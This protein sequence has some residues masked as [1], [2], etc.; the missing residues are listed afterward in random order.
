MHA[1]HRTQTVQFT[2]EGLV[3]T[4]I[5]SI[6]GVLLVNHLVFRTKVSKVRHFDSNFEFFPNL[7]WK[8]NPTFDAETQKVPFRIGTG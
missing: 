7:T 5:R 6:L 4:G 1:T 3:V 8:N 2:T